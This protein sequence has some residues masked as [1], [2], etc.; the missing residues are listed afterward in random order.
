MRGVCVGEFLEKIYNQQAAALG[1]E[2]PL[3]GRARYLFVDCH[4]SPIT[5]QTVKNHLNAIHGKLCLS[6]RLSLAIYAVHTS[7]YATP[8]VNLLP[9]RHAI[10]EPWGPVIWAG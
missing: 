2:L 9:L 7:L 6:D 3:P 10:L 5:E 4:A 8:K 1:L